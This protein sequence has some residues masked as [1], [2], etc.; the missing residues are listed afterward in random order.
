MYI[1]NI[2]ILF[3]VIVVLLFFTCSTDNGYQPYLMK[4]IAKKNYHEI[5]RQTV[6]VIDVG[7]LV[8]AGHTIAILDYHD[9]YYERWHTRV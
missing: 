4:P 8:E 2:K 1:K 9:M 3:I 6:T 5:L 7:R